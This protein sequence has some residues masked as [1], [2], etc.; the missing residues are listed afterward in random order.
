MNR[1]LNYLVFVLLLGLLAFANDRFFGL[2]FSDEQET[3]SFTGISGDY[4]VVYTMPDAKGVVGYGGNVPMA[5]AVSGD[6]TIKAI[7]VLKNAES[8]TFLGVAIDDGYLNNWIGK[9]MEYAAIADVDA[10]TGATLSTTAIAKSIKL[11]AETYLGTST[12]KTQSQPIDMEKLLKL[13]AF[14]FVVFVGVLFFFIPKTFAKHRMLLLVLSVAVLGIWQGS[15]LSVAKISAWFLNGVPDV[16]QYGLFFAFAISI[17]LPAITGRNF[18]CYHLCPFG[19]AQEIVGKSVSF[20]A[21]FIKKILFKGLEKMRLII[22][23]ACFMLVLFGL[24]TNI[25]KL[26][27]FAA[28]KPELAPNIAVAIFVISLILSMFV[29]RP[30]CKYF[31]PCGAFLDLFKRK[32]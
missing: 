7:K 10:V 15:M 13:C 26:E 4:K 27:P 29:Q 11:R 30:W 17:I 3:V 16:W 24:G 14:L 23:L 22:L 19:A 31:C 6:N 32:N 5:L 1:I 18:Y 21:N 8:P 28:F 20:N 2:S 25:V 9:T 12:K